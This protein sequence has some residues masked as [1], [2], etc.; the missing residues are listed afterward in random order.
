MC[1]QYYT[2]LKNHYR[3]NKKLTESIREISKIAGYKVNIQKSKDF[4][5]THK[6]TKQTNNWRTYW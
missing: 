2:I 1:T 4:L 6:K 3:T 5:Y